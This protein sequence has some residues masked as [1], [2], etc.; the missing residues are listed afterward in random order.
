[1]ALTKEAEIIEDRLKS[2]TIFTVIGMM[3]G[4]SM[5]GIDLALLRTDGIDILEVL[6]T[7]EFP[8]SPNFKGKLEEGL[9]YGKKLTKGSE[10]SVFLKALES[11]ITDHH[12]AAVSQF[13]ATQNINAKEIDAIGF[14]GQTILHRPDLGFTI[15]FGD[16][17]NLAD[18]T[19][20]PVV[21][22]MR[23][24]DLDHGG[25]GAPLVPVF[26]KALQ[27]KID[28]NLPD[29]LREL[30][31]VAFVNIGG[32]SNISYIGAN[33]EL[34]AFD[35]GPGNALIDQWV[36]CEAGIPYDQ[37]GAIA[38]E[39]GI[40]VQVADQYLANSFFDQSVPK[41]LDRNDFPPLESGSMNLEDGARTL[42]HISA[43]AIIKSC[44][45]LP[46]PPKL[47]II[48]G[49]GRKNPAI[50]HDLTTL[51]SE[52]NDA[53]VILSEIVGLD[54]DSMEAEAW[55]Y[56]AARSIK[57]LPLTFPKTTGCREAVRGGKLVFPNERQTK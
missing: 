51:A 41:S 9:R 31:P 45:H 21:Y 22:D 34:I 39:G 30:L 25:Q 13:L 1:M 16:G 7:A 23:S 17:Q 33:D 10:R 53:K 18:Q 3:S 48:C 54:G 57:D 35:T 8:Y 2:K 15:Q 43:A 29:E 40:L 6:Q 50:M 42:A 27:K 36:Q 11:E 44:D 52:K 32:I 49:G 24:N 19:S 26:H 5:D 28:E 14:H 12:A 46:V 37:G 47:W 4:T 56:L 55:A 38:A 20:I